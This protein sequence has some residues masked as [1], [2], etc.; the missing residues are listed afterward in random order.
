MITP[1]DK[2]ALLG[3][4]QQLSGMPT[5][6][7]NFTSMESLFYSVLHLARNYGNNRSDNPLLKDFLE[8]KHSVYS[9]TQKA[10]SKRKQRELIIFQFKSA[11]KKKLAIWAH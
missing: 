10:F 6:E 7:R 11:F 8:I 4:Y 1:T 3:I 2:Q 5:A 9:E